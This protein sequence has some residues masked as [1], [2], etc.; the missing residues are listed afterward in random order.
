MNIII[1]QKKSINY[2]S[3]SN[4]PPHILFWTPPIAKIEICTKNGYLWV[5]LTLP[6]MIRGCILK[7]WLV[8]NE[9]TAIS[10]TYL[11]IF[12]M[13]SRILNLS[14]LSFRLGRFNE[15]GMSKVLSILFILIRYYFEWNC[16]NDDI[17]FWWRYCQNGYLCISNRSIIIDFLMLLSL[18]FRVNIAIFVHFS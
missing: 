1:F 7:L 9:S 8:A 2:L 18:T 3:L 14:R 17:L 6:F 12:E 5:S 16:E 15:I 10:S 13:I 11:I 4:V